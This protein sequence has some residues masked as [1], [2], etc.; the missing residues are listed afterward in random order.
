MQKDSLHDVW[1]H[2]SVKWSQVGSPLRPTEEDTRIMLMLSAPALS[3]GEGELLG[4]CSWRY[5]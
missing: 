5:S 4:Y 1:K 2:H 3:H